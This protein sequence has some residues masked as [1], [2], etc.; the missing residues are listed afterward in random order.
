M[1]SPGADF[2]ASL[3]G[4][5]LIIRSIPSLQTTRV[6]SVAG[7]HRGKTDII[8]WGPRS[9]QGNASSRVLLADEENVR[10]WDL[11]DEQW[12]AHIN[13]GSGG[14]GK[15]VNAEFGRTS[16]EVLVVSDFGSKI[17]VWSLS[18]GRS[19]EIR[20]PKFAHRGFAYRP[21]TGL[22]V[23]LSRPDAQDIVTMHAPQ[24]YAVL[25]TIM[26]S[27]LDGQGL[28]WSPD[29]HWLAIW[30][31]P[32]AGYRLWIYTA[33]GHLYREY[34]G[35][36]DE[37]VGGLGIRSIQWSPRR[38]FLALASYDKRVTLLS[39]RTVCPI[40]TTCARPRDML[41]LPCSSLRS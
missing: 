34:N 15:I 1:L 19:V 6:I 12:S 7:D 17:A 36:S 24:T 16:D 32:S 22:F 13:N 29:G 27:S 5:R 11:S 18:S 25:Q 8:R 28:K 2:V 30:D 3:N 26:L 4:S 21:T 40:S 10:V 20:D 33:D 38:D 35:D 41:M 37:D 14:M 9:Q 39:T 23:V 31:A